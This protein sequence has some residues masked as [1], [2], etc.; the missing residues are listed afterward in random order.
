MF[1]QATWIFGTMWV[2]RSAKTQRTVPESTSV[3]GTGSAP[4][5]PANQPASGAQPSCFCQVGFLG[6]G[7]DVTAISV[8]RSAKQKKTAI[9]EGMFDFEQS[10]FW[11]R[12][13]KKDA[14]CESLER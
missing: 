14:L 13:Q 5:F 2:T 4:V 1:D 9:A 3:T 12:S 11:I 7:S 8:P 10:D 6:H